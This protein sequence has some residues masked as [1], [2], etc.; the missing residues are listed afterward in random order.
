MDKKHVFGELEKIYALYDEIKDYYEYYTEKE[1]L[2]Q[3]LSEKEKIE[4]QVY[5][6]LY[7]LAN[8]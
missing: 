1:I 7:D 3:P 6:H 8:K 2:G 4:Y 5:R